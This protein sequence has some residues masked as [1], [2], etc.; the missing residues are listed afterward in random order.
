MDYTLNCHR[1]VKY[2]KLFLHIFQLYVLR[3]LF[4]W[5]FLSVMHYVFL[6]IGFSYDLSDDIEGES[7]RIYESRGGTDTLCSQD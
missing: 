6:S 5:F 2:L 4:I 1:K 7:R 3:I